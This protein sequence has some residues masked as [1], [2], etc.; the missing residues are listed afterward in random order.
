[1]WQKFEFITELATKLLTET[2]KKL[3]NSNFVIHKLFRYH[4]FIDILRI[5][6]N[7]ELLIKIYL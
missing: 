4:D 1:M 2:L 3:S 6:R 7:S 5:T